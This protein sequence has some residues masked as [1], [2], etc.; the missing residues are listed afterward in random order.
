M[1]EGQHPALVRAVNGVVEAADEYDDLL[2][3]APVAKYVLAAYRWARHRRIRA[4]IGALDAGTKRLSEE[5]QA[6]FQEYLESK[7]GLELLADYAEAVMRSTSRVVTAALAVLYSDPDHFRFPSKFKAAAI[8]ALEG[9][10]DKAVDAFLLLAAERVR[11]P[12]VPGDAYPVH[13]LRNSVVA[14]SNALIAWSSDGLQWVSTLNDLIR[15]G[16]LAPDSSAGMRLGDD[17]QSWC[18]YFGFSDS[19]DLFAELLSTAQSY[20]D[21]E[22]RPA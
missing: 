1:S 7:Q 8:P 15:R 22:S 2:K 17:E 16:L 6:R 20:V 10:S 11:L 19:S 21:R 14:D 13:A 3:L 18:V 12:S 9:L 4:F 5:G